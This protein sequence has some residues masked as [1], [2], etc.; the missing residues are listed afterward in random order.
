VI[1]LRYFAGLRERLGVGEE[2]I[3]L[4]EGVEDV[5][6]LARWLQGRDDHWRQAL[7]DSRLRVAVN[8]Q[9]ATAGACIGDGDEIAWFPPVTGG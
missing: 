8:Q 9:I 7:A 6:A 1:T 5:A 4:P 2:R 3:D